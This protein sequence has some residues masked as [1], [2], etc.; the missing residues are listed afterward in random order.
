MR[1]E[2]NMLVEQRKLQEEQVWK[3]VE[4]HME[5]WE[6][7]EKKVDSIAE[8]AWQMN[9]SSESK[10]KTWSTIGNTFRQRQGAQVVDK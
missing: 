9:Q 3:M 5:S 8:K 4:Q 7:T 10:G 1:D 2:E 6:P